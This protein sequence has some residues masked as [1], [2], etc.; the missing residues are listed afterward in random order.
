MDDRGLGGPGVYLVVSAT[1]KV[2][3]DVPVGA[4][5]G[6]DGASVGGPSG[7]VVET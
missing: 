4:V 7:C 6:R 5:S 2:S 3:S 1:G